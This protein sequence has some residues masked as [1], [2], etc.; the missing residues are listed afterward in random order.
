MLN[1]KKTV[2]ESCVVNYY[3]A[4]GGECQ[5]RFCMEKVFLHLKF[6]TNDESYDCYLIQ[7][8][9]FVFFFKEVDN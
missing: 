8:L 5:L 7:V 6:G 9:S 4:M 3:V 2:Y 1:L